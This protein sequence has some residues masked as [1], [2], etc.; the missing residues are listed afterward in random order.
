MRNGLLPILLAFAATPIHALTIDRM[1]T[2]PSGL[3]IQRYD[4][5]GYVSQRSFMIFGP[6][7]YY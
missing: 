5:A 7:A 1:F 3:Y 4:P 2:T 6:A